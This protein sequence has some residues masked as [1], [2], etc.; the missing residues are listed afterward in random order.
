MN[1]GVIYQN[2]QG[3]E[4][5]FERK[6]PDGHINFGESIRHSNINNMVKKTT[7]YTVHSSR[8]ASGLA[9]I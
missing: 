9:M 1:D 6:L 2:G 8:E 3:R 7:K 5:R 4:N